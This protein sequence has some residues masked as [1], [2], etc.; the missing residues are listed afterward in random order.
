MKK[1][2]A[3]LLTLV[4]ILTMLS[5]CNTPAP[6]PVEPAKVAKDTITL[7]TDIEPD[8]L[9]PRR[10]NSVA[11]NIPM[12]LIYDS[13]IFLNDEAEFEPRLAT[14]WEVIDDTHIRF[15]LREGVKFSNG[16]DF[17]ADDVLFSLNRTKLDSTSLS[18]MKWYDE[19]NSKVENAHSIIVAM[20]YPYAPAFQV[21]AG[22][23][24]WIGSKK[25]ME[26]MGEEAHARNPVGTGP[27]KL[28]TW[29]T[30]AS[31][32]LTRNDKFWGEAAKTEK[33]LFKYSAESTAR[34]IALETKEVDFAYYING[35]DKA[36]V[37][38]IDGYHI[39]S[40]TSCKYYTIV[41]NMQNEKFAN[42]KVRY[43]LSYAID[44]KALVDAGFDGTATVMS[45]ILPSKVEG[46]KDTY[47]TWEYNPEKA[48][49]L[50]AEAGATNL[51]FE[52]HIL[53]TA[54]FQKL[55]EIIQSFWAKVGVTVN[56]EQSALAAREA[57][58]PWEASIRNGN[59]T[60]PTGILIIY[61][62]LFASRVGSNDDVLDAM[63]LK[64]QQ[65][66]DTAER[67]KQ[68][69]ELQDYIYKIRF[70]IPFAETDTIYGVGDHIEGYEF[71]WQIS[72]CNIPDWIV[73]QVKK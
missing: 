28:T 23:R 71:T 38:A 15:T 4:L 56:I 49:A 66:Y 50:L 26:E 60:D 63:L 33:V 39:E 20:K 65:T 62:S 44:L 46:W 37:D 51:S 10:G 61:D 59:A 32:L 2:I 18:T 21:L 30:G 70:T 5:G 43:A 12:K 67:A 31:M 8:T 57:Q 48:K 6:V 14:K 29:T 41:F 11:N 69:A 22:G 1:R 24:T 36:R 25:T 68:L 17:T 73:Y 42:E 54:E 7:V 19:V 58:G 40:G 53:P 55:A 47:G 72:N 16:Y 64:L 34:V 3:V 27:Y 13:L 52:L 9:D 35:P 45:S